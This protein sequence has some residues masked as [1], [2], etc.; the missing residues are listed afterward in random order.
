MYEAGTG[1]NR[2][3]KPRKTQRRVDRFPK[4]SWAA[5]RY[6]QVC[7]YNKYIFVIKAVCFIA[8]DIRVLNVF[9]I[10]HVKICYHYET[11]SK[12]N[13][14]L[15]ITENNNYRIISLKNVKSL[16]HVIRVGSYVCIRLNNL[17][18]VL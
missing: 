2:G 18:K 16:S 9:S 4:H 11:K 7:E 15:P 13:H 3:A 14:I 10:T 12:I 1:V 17:R 5:L 6:E 8:P